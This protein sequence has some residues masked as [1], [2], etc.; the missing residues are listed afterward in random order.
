MCPHR[1]P[2]NLH[3]TVSIGYSLDEQLIVVLHQ[4]VAPS[5]QQSRLNE[6]LGRLRDFAEKIIWRNLCNATVRTR[7]NELRRSRHMSTHFL[8]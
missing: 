1:N 8:D 5:S 4:Q 6:P 3:K 7:F 2:D